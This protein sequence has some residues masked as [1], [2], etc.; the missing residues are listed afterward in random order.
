MHRLNAVLLTSALALLCLPSQA[1]EIQ[2]YSCRNGLFPTE[3]KGALLYRVSSKQPVHFFNDDKGCPASE[4][5]KNKAY[6]VEGNEVLVSKAEGGWACVWHQGPQ[7]ETVGWVAVDTLLPMAEPVP[8]P[9][10]WL[11]AWKSYGHAITIKKR[12]GALL[13]VSGKATWGTGEA[14][15][16]GRVDGAL[17]IQGHH[18][19]TR[20]GD[21]QDAC[22]VDLTRIGRYLIVSDNKNCGG[23][24]VSFDGVYVRE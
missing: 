21:D 12:E 11:G 17:R 10:A 16:Y 9:D 5:C 22:L 13:H 3:G 4:A 23:F 24:N 1:Q 18:A 19:Q 7:H 2:P 15:H 20:M 8:A 6:I 14:K